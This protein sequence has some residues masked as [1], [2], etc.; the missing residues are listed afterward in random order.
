MLQHQETHHT[1]LLEQ[2]VW[3]HV[4]AAKKTGP[5]QHLQAV[6]REH[7]PFAFS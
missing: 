3:C 4:E 5:L 7:I 1:V 2:S 6:I